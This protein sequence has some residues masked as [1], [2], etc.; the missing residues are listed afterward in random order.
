MIPHE[1]I[2]IFSLL[3]W[4]SNIVTFSLI[5]IF[6]LLGKWFNL[7]N[8]NNLAKVIGIDKQ[9]HD[10]QVKKNMLPFEREI[11][12]TLLSDFIKEENER[13]KAQQRKSKS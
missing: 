7:G 3:W 6:L 13:I 2:E 4:Q 5:L 12:V 9:K 1:T 11:Y 8:R 10:A